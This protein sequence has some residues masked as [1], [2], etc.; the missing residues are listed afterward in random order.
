MDCLEEHLD[1]LEQSCKETVEK[2]VEDVEENPELDR[3][4][5]DSCK[6]FWT[7]HCKVCCTLF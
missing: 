6:Q 4:F 5:S 7:K 1:E 2:F 3:I